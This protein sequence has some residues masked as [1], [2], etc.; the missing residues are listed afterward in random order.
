MPIFTLEL[1]YRSEDRTILNATKNTMHI[2]RLKC[3][4]L[5]VAG[6]TY[7]SRRELNVIRC[8]FFFH[9]LYLMEIMSEM[10]PSLMNVIDL[11]ASKSRLVYFGSKILDSSTETAASSS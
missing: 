11:Q 2:R 4:L 5:R 9:L 6:R 7:E 3:W 1:C 10:M 8:N